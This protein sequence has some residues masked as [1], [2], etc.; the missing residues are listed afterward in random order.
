MR[1]GFRIPELLAN[2]YGSPWL[3]LVRQS[4][5]ASRGRLDAPLAQ[6]SA[7]SSCLWHR[8]AVAVQ[9]Q[10]TSLPRSSRSPPCRRTSYPCARERTHAAERAAAALTRLNVLLRIFR[11]L[12]PRCRERS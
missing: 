2:D 11:R 4:R 3:L 6:P 5:D 9:K 10:P 12:P 1:G 8:R 7:R